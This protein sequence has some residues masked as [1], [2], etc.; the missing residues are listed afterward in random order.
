[1]MAAKY[2][3]K[4]GIS[5]IFAQYEKD[6][7]KFESQPKK[8]VVVVVVVTERNFLSQGEISCHRKNFPVTGRNIL[9]QEE[10][11]CPCFRK[12]LCARGRNF[13]ILFPKLQGE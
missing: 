13:P 3:L 8:V 1:M 7:T 12:K 2:C 4:I 9:S 10:V 6:I 11:S 5:F